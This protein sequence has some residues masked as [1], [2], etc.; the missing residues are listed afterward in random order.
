MSNDKSK[1]AIALAKAVASRNIPDK[2][3]EDVAQQLSSIEHEIKGI[4]ICKY[5]ICVDFWTNQPINGTDIT[6][7]LI[8]ANL[9]ELKIFEYGIINPDLFHTKADIQIDQLS[10]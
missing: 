8:N 5:G 2:T 9:G 10:P 6:T 7:P 4:D 1:V 3:I